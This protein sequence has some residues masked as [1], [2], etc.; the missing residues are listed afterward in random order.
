MEAVIDRRRARCSRNW[1]RSGGL[2]LRS[3]GAVFAGHFLPGRL[4]QNARRRESYGSLLGA[5]L[6]PSDSR[7]CYI[8][9]LGPAAR[10]DRIARGCEIDK[11]LLEALR[12]MSAQ[13]D[14]QGQAL[15]GIQHLAI[16]RPDSRCGISWWVSD[17]HDVSCSMACSLDSRHIVFRLLAAARQ[18]RTARTSIATAWGRWKI[19]FCHAVRT[20]EDFRCM[21]CP[22]KR[23]SLPCRGRRSGE[24]DARLLDEDADLVDPNRCRRAPKGIKR[25]HRISRSSAVR[26]YRATTATSVGSPGSGLS[27]VQAMAHRIGNEINPLT[28]ER[29][30]RA[31]V[32]CAKPSAC[33]SGRQANTSSASVPT[34]R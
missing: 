9:E 29:R 28:V 16:L 12:P 24:K 22:T 27:R 1:I 3:N 33:R 11:R 21:V 17:V 25:V 10:I 8:V 7:A 19:Q 2:S 6:M 23:R 14:M 31:V 18:R 15:Q 4:R 30:G 34:R 20:R 32:A 13:F 5:R 26:F